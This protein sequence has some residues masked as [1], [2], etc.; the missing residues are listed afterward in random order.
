[1]K[2]LIIFAFVAGLAC[3]QSQSVWQDAT[4]GWSDLN[5]TP[6]L[7]TVTSV[8]CGTGLTGGAITTTG[9]CALDYT[10]AHSAP[11]YAV[12][13]THGETATRTLTTESIT[14]ALSGTTTDSSANLLPANS[15]ILALT[16]RV[17]T[18]I[19]GSTDFAFTGKDSGKAYGAVQT[20]LTAG[21]TG[22]LFPTAY[23]DGFV[24]TAEKLRITTTGT[25]TAGV[26]RVTLFVET[27]VPPTS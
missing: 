18:T 24:T 22:V 9:V 25:A 5:A 10:V 3:A 8:T 12:T 21:T 7:G 19:T 20:V 14:L 4:N 1:M 2:K 23:G 17:T 16:Y 26:I 11:S 15:R 6:G 13:G 27:Y